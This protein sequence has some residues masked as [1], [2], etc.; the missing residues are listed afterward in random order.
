MSYTVPL[1]NARKVSSIPVARPGVICLS[2]FKSS[3]E[4][5]TVIV[6]KSVVV[7]S[8]PFNSKIYSAR[9]KLLELPSINSVTSSVLARTVSSNVSVSDPD[10]RSIVKLVSCGSVVSGVKSD[11]RKPSLIGLLAFLFLE[12]SFIMLIE[13][14]VVMN[15]SF[16]SVAR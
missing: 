9:L 7:E 10:V 13:G 12:A 15:V 2:S 4:N 5:S 6:V 14:S 8:P 11:T 1:A 3:I 16:S